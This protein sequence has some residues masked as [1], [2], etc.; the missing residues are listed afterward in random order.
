MARKISTLEVATIVPVVSLD[1]ARVVE[2]VGG[3][4]AVDVRPMHPDQ[5]SGRWL[6]G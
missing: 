5:V 3:D 1:N 6:L 2:G 4:E